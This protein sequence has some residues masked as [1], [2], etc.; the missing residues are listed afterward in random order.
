MKRII[1]RQL[2]CCASALFLV[3]GCSSS[4]H[5]QRSQV[6]P[7]GTYSLPVMETTD[8]HGTL[9]NTS[10]GTNHYRL[11]YIADKAND[12]RGRG[13]DYDT[14]KLLLLDGGDI[15]QGTVL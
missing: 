13:A 10:T 7:Q 15:Y 11:A 5:I 1:L 6:V 14:Q 3:A 4:R 12:I 8:V 9:V 2:V